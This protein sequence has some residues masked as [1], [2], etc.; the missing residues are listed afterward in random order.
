MENWILEER[1]KDE[2]NEFCVC[3]CGE[4]ENIQD[5]LI[6]QNEYTGE[7]F[8]ATKINLW[9]SR[10]QEWKDALRIGNGKT[11]KPCPMPLQHI[12]FRP[13]ALGYKALNRKEA[14]VAEF[15]LPFIPDVKQNQ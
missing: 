10:L 2:Q 8:I 14:E 7:Y 12:M 6:V 13:N 1:I 15:S 4:R 9:Q 3:G 11:D 5:G